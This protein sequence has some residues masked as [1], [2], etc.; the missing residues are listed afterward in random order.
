MTRTILNIGCTYV[1]FFCG[2]S[3]I[4]QNGHEPH[5]NYIKFHTRKHSC[6]DQV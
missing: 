6:L 5:R 2:R 1:V 3:Q 4:L